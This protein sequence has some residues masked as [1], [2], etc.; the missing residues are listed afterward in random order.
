MEDVDY[1]LPLFLS[2][3]QA[4]LFSMLSPAISDGYEASLGYHQG[5]L[6]TQR[7][8]AHNGVSTH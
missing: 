8:H 1:S 6:L 7:A 3:Y 2:S 5:I 4:M